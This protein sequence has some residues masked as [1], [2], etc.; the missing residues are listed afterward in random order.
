MGQVRGAWL[1]E[2]TI[3]AVSMT[4]VREYRILAIRNESQSLLELDQITHY[5]TAREH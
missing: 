4:V 3:K 2:W 1:G 5:V